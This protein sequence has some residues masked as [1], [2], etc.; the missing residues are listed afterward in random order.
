MILEPV[1]SENSMQASP[2][3]TL[4]ALGLVLIVLPGIVSAGTLYNV[5]N[6]GNFSGNSATPTSIS[7]SGSEIVGYGIQNGNSY[8][9]SSSGGALASMAFEGQANGGN[10]TGQIV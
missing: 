10:N 1:T 3:K 8:A 9:A 2:N 4:A 6:L 5:V 7:S